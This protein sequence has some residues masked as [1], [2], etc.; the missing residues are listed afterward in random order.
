VVR[1]KVGS[2]AFPWQG[3]MQFSQSVRVEGLVFSSGQA[4]FLP[5]GGLAGPDFE[6][7]CRRAFANL[8][9]VLRQQGASVDSLVRLNAFFAHASHYADF[10]RIR[11]EWLKAPYPASTA[12]VTGFVFPGMLV[13]LEGIAVRGGEARVL[14]DGT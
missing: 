12:V 9:Q 13:E 14:D 2:F 7:Q 11:G 8:D 1:P 5:E 6:S 4:G 3:E 10:R